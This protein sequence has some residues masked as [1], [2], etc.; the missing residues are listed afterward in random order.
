MNLQKEHF[1]RSP[2]SHHYYRIPDMEI[3]GRQLGKSAKR[4]CVLCVLFP[5]P[6]LL[7]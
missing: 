6:L 5:A 7:L 2:G 3:D 4:P 1:F